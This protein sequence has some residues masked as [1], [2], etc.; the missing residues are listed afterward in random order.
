MK[1][2]VFI[3]AIVFGCIHS[4][5]I[6]TL[7]ENDRH[8]SHLSNLERELSFRSEMGLY[9]SYYKQLVHAPSY[10][11]GLKLLLNDKLTE[12]PNKIN[13]IKKFNIYP[14]VISALLYRIFN[15]TINN[16]FNTNLIE[17]WAISRGQ[18]A[19][20]ESCVGFG[21]PI[22]FYVYTVCGMVAITTFSL[23]LCGY[24]LSDSFIGS[25]M[26]VCAFFYN[27]SEATRVMWTIPLRESFG[28][29]LFILQ[30]LLVTQVLK[31]RDKAISKRKPLFLM[32]TLSTFAFLLTWQ[33]GPFILF[34]QVS[35]LFA[36][37][38]VC[39]NKYRN[40]NST[41]YGL[42]VVHFAS[43]L[44]AWIFL[45]FNNAIITSL[46]LCAIIS[47]L[48]C[49]FCQ[50]CFTDHK[51]SSLPGAKH[52]PQSLVQMI[53]RMIIF[54]LVY[55]AIVIIIK[56]SLNF[57]FR[58]K[59]DSHVYEILK[60]KFSNYKNFHTM[61]YTCSAEFDF[62]SKQ[63]YINLTRTALLPA[64]LVA[65]FLS[66]IQCFTVS[67]YN[68]GDESS[69][70]KQTSNKNLKS[71]LEQLLIAQAD[72]HFYPEVYF[73][74]FQAI[75]FLCLASIIMRLKLLATPHL[76]LLSS[77]LANHQLLIDLLPKKIKRSMLTKF[78]IKSAA[79]ALLA[80][81]SLEGIK[82]I[83]KEQSHLGEYINLP[84]EEMINWIVR[85]TAE[86]KA[87]AG[88]MS[89]MANIKLSADRPI[90]NNPFYED[91]NMRKIT[92]GIYT[93][94]SRKPLKVVH[95]LLQ[96]MSAYYAVVEDNW[97]FYQSSDECTLPS[98]WD[99][100]DVKNRR[101][102]PACILLRTKNHDSKYFETVFENRECTIVRVKRLKK[103]PN[104]T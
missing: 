23:F 58:Y 57:T 51:E 28:Y 45:F 4:Y 79:I 72:L 15:H 44:L 35:S 70:P 88:P 42:V 29:P 74:S 82:N 95:A 30:S 40:L 52:I 33:F 103:L 68:K 84:Q 32:T 104:I 92:K 22:Y 78:F 62:L 53:G 90:I 76:C 61:L 60:G 37:N 101:R 69:T 31:T 6:Y 24:L 49:L 81:M 63:T 99:L 85:N 21:E 46:Y 56:Y 54:G 75:I 12:Y 97:C 102:E 3:T 19:S 83:H 38:I 11:V 96:N 87:F 100:E 93:L 36:L 66:L 10:N 98:I 48:I 73:T 18:H 34:T 67:S 71:K 20:V 65:A 59:D 2:P 13:I 27:H 1:I 86:D 91:T 43:L 25:I 89:V 8:F 41:L 9:Y 80:I 5:Y 26:V 64:S 39:A 77:V 55:C 16:Y 50:N 7:F 17:C 14:E 94:Y 47:M